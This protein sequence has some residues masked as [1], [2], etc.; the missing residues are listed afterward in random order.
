[1]DGNLYYGLNKGDHD[2]DSSTAST[3]GIFKVNMD[4]DSGV[5]YSEFMADASATGSNDGAVDPRAADPFAEI[6]A[7]AGILIRNPEMQGQSGGDD[8][9]RGGEGRDEMYGGGGDDLLH[10]GADD[11][12]L[13][14]DGGA[15]SINGGTGDDALFGGAGDDKLTGGQGDDA[16]SGGDGADYLNAGSGDDRLDGGAGADKLVGGAGSDTITGGAGNDHMWGGNWWKDGAQD[17]FVI[18][19]GSGKDMIHDFEADKDM[20]DLSSYGIEYSEVTAVMAD[21]G[22]ATEIDLSQLTGGQVADKLIIKSVDPDELDE[23]N[24]IL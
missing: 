14:G 24:F 18:S 4:W 9:L 5:A 3:G 8:D 6:D 16:L 7:N 2:L 17:T 20:I 1:G 22:W 23:T 19:A 11:D 15:D 21:K 13:S 12:T 10:G